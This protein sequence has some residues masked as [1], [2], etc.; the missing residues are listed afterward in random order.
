MK[1]RVAISIILWSM[2][3]LAA[4]DS[5]ITNT[6]KAKA[7]DNSSNAS[8]IIH[9]ASSS[10][11]A[12]FFNLPQTSNSILSFTLCLTPQKKFVDKI[13]GIADKIPNKREAR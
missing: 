2:V 11:F 12:Y 10:F 5:M 9:S 13:F 3:V 7:L 1:K 8:K 4:Q 6:K